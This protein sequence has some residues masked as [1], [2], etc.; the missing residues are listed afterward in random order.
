MTVE[1]GRQSVLADVRLS[2]TAK[3]VLEKRYLKKDSNGRVIETPEDMFHRVARVVASAEC[4]YAP[5]ADTSRIEEEFYQAMSRLEFLPNSPTLLNAGRQVGQLSACFVLPV[6][7]S[8]ESIFDAVKQTALIHKSGGGTGF[9][10]SN[11]RPAGDKVGELTEVAGGPVSVINIFSAA[12]DYVRQGGVR[13]GCN[14]A[15]LDVTHPDIL[16][17]IS[18]KGDPNALTNFYISVVVTRE[19]MT[20]VRSGEDYGIINPHTGEVV[21]R[22]N[23]ACVFDCIV[24]QAW[25]TGEPGLVFIDRINDDNPTPELGRIRHVSGCGEQTLLP[26]ESCNLGSIS[27]PRM[28]KRDGERVVVDYEKL[29]RTVKMAIRFLDNVIDVNK[30][31]TPEIEKATLRNRKIGLGVMGFADMLVLMGIPYNSEEAIFQADQ[32]MD[33]IKET[34]HRA[35]SKLAEARGSFPAYEGSIY[36]VPGGRPMRNATCTSIAPTGTLSI[37]AGVSSGIE[38]SFAMVFVRNILD[39]ENLLEINP[40]FEEMA[41]R[42]GFHSK[43]LFEKLVSSNHLHDMECVP[44]WLKRLLVTAHRIRPEWHIRIQAA[45]QKYTDNAVSKTVNFSHEATREDMANVFNL[46]YD[47]GLKGITVYRD[48]SRATQPL[49]TSESGVKLVDQYLDNCSCH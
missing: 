4:K 38:P 9:S 44:D 1:F 6:E 33:F 23:A 34:S 16:K 42:E 39:G 46:A 14:A 35:S 7:D 8:I 28:L 18:C 10:F 5:G 43:E 30:F 27:L 13:R 40:Y 11:L 19:F 21:Q 36:D 20:K 25:K 31:P 49:C 22:L 45:F 12:A 17:F 26:Y 32:I 3:R 29:G 24:D 15:I 48:G 37:I 47:K 41:R 2:T